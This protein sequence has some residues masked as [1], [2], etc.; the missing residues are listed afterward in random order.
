MYKKLHWH[1]ARE[2]V[3]FSLQV[4]KDEFLTPPPPLPLKKGETAKDSTRDSGAK[5]VSCVFWEGSRAL[6]CRARGSHLARERPQHTCTGKSYMVWSV[7]RGYIRDYISAA[8][9][10]IYYSALGRV[11]VTSASRA[12]IHYIRISPVERSINRYLY[13]ALLRAPTV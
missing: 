7:R 3:I 8:H 1:L 5:R 9:N 12:W 13:N 10:T 4:S 11:V 2:S 6:F